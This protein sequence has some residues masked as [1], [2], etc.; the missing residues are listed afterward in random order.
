VAVE[1]Q[2]FEHSV[3]PDPVSPGEGQRMLFVLDL[4]GGALPARLR[5][6]EHRLGTPRPRA[7]R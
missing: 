4:Q 6:D 7:T 5:I 2:D 3:R 1:A